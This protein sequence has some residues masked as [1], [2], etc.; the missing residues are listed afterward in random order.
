MRACSTRVSLT[1]IGGVRRREARN[2]LEHSAAARLQLAEFDV[3][4]A[5]AQIGKRHALRVVQATR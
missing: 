5:D 2:A 4:V 3:R 1:R